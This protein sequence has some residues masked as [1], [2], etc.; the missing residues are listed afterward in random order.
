MATSTYPPTGNKYIDG[1]LAVLAQFN[2]AFPIAAGAVMGIL[3]LFRS[4]NVGGLPTDAEAIQLLRKVAEADRDANAAW[5]AEHGF[6]T[7]PQT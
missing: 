7:S 6:G 2:I 3:A 5:L 1:I 4:Q